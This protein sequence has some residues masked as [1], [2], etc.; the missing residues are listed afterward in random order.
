MTVSSDPP[1]TDPMSGPAPDR[2]LDRTPDRA[3]NPGPAGQAVTGEAVTG[4]TVAGSAPKGSAQEGRAS[5]VGTP[6]AG[7]P[8][9]FDVVLSGTVFLDIIF[10]GLPQ[11][12][13][14][15]TEVWASGLGSSPGGVAN[16]AVALSRLRLRTGLAAAFGEDV[17]GDFCWDVLANQE[18]VDLTYSRRFY[19]WHS[20]LTVSMAVNR[21]RS[22]VTH[23]H[24]APITADE[25]LT[26]PPSTRACFVH[27][28]L[29][30][31]QWVRTAKRDGALLFA[32][33]GWDPTERWE[34][35]ML[36]QLAGYDVFMPNAVEAVS[37]TRCDDVKQ[38]ANALAEVVPVVVVTRG[39][40]GAYA[41]D[42]GTGEEVDVPGLNVAALDPT[43]AGDVFGAGFVYG[44]LAGW[45]LSDRVHFANL[46]AALSVQ[47]FGG[48]LSAPGWCDLAAW[49]RHLGR[50]DDENLR[51]Y[52]FL[53]DLL[54]QHGCATVRRASATIGLRGVP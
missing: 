17:Y 29:H 13:A 46:C 8:P 2:G 7:R 38:A 30:E 22:M 14:A 4:R 20:P 43:G 49:W 15:G 33:V 51:G 3:S 48:S 24:P 53:N 32:D 39:G 10:T 42:A 23:G 44:T 16:L 9:G 36:Q 18:H 21:D 45:S 19:G 5:E 25:L 47:H 37:Y 12:P 26:P 35:R 1:V 6:D 11:A 31:D 50:R 27:V 28:D 40:H 41:V 54:P 52:G 34:P